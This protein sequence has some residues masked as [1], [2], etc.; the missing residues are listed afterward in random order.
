[1]DRDRRSPPLYLTL[2]RSETDSPVI[3]FIGSTN[4]REHGTRK[5][6]FVVRSAD[7]GATW[8][9][10]DLVRSIS[11]DT[12][13]RRPTIAMT[14]DA[15]LHLMWL[16]G[17]R[18]RPMSYV[19]HSVSRDNGR[20]WARSDG[21]TLPGGTD[22]LVAASLPS[23]GFI[24]AGRMPFT[25]SIELAS[26]VAGR[27]SE[28]TAPFAEP[29]M[30]I[31]TVSVVQNSLMLT[32]GVARPHAIPAAPSTPAPELVYSLGAVTCRGTN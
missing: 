2:A 16:E 28:L 22:M 18:P 25:G 27:W 10:P 11:G 26:W 9:T 13:A 19:G 4:D 15:A 6:V 31:P 17:I 30:S 14:T 8:D 12:V 24:V 29:A 7:G 21:L 20:S 23:N 1:V 32:W 5:G 3:A